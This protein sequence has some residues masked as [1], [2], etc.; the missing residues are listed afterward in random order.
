MANFVLESK[1]H[2]FMSRKSII[3]AIIA[4]MASCLFMG[5]AWAK[6]EKVKALVVSGQNNHNW[7][8]SHKVLKMILDNSGMFATDIV[9]TAPA[10]GDMSGFCPE[11]SAGRERACMNRRH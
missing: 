7:P 2:L 6:G 5:N 10:G 3:I 9:L 8:V 11:F 1:K 4:L